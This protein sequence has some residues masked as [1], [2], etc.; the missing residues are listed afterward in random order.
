M[1]LPSDSA[2]QNL[3]KYIQKS[4]SAIGT[5]RPVFSQKN[6]S[7]IWLSLGSNFVD[8]WTGNKKPFTVYH[9]VTFPL[10]NKP[11]PKLVSLIMTA[12]WTVKWTPLLSYK[13]AAGH[14]S[15]G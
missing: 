3:S 14:V 13:I 2:G 9:R 8:F 4:P 10:Q 5:K 1:K 11:W 7:Q 12:Q 15:T 6:F